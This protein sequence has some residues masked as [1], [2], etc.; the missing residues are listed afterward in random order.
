M[1]WYT[2]AV[3]ERVAAAAPVCSAFTFGS[4]AAHWL[5]SGQCD[6]IYYHNTYLWTSRSL[7]RSSRRARCFSSAQG[8]LLE[9]DFMAQQL[10]SRPTLALGILCEPKEFS[11]Q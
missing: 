7:A 4:Q 2:A 1:T 10:F 11:P 3:D 9:F 5:A 8:S 6:C